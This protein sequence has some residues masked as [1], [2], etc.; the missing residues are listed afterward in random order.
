MTQR[1]AFI[2]KLRG[3]SALLVM[4]YHHCHFFWMNQDFC[5]RLAHRPLI[6]DIPWIAKF[7]ES[8]PINFGNLGVAIFFLISGFL[9]P[10][11]AQNK[12]RLDFLKR[13]LW[14]IW[15]AYVIALL[16]TMFLVYLSSRN[17]QY[18]SFFSWSH[19]HIATSLFLIRDIGGY[20][21][22]DGIVWTLEIEIKFYLLC[23]ITRTW[24][25]EKPIKFILLIIILALLSLV[26]MNYR[27]FIET[28]FIERPMR[29]FFKT[30]KFV[31]FMGLGC[32]LS[33]IYQ[34]KITIRK[35]FIYSLILA[36]LYFG[37]FIHTGKHAVEW[38]E[39]VSYSLA[40]LLFATCYALR[41]KFLNSGIMAYIGKISYSLYLVHGVP[42]FVMIYW[43]IS[44]DIK[45]FTAIIITIFC[46]LLV[47]KVF[48]WLVENNSIKRGLL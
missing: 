33:Y 44:Q 13:R 1:I 3:I 5:G 14:R 47:A 35:T 8:L 40:Y 18:P 41:E 21:L 45:P 11:A 48:Y 43:I 4:F 10:I 6:A 32:L 16:L 2:L 37:H 34:K 28:V 20:P 39:I 24:L 30:M 46:L 27:H 23:F 38:K 26:L 25:V 9:M 17:N 12:T 36:V 29:I 42:G 15:P 7:L 31:C 19:G 22:I